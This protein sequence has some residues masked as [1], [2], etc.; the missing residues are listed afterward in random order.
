MCLADATDQAAQVCTLMGGDGQAWP[1]MWVDQG[2]RCGVLLLVLDTASVGFFL[3][4]HE[5]TQDFVTQRTCQ[6][7]SMLTVISQ[8]LWLGDCAVL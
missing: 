1:G 2:A 7:R 4:L 8:L 5:S 6:L 3:N